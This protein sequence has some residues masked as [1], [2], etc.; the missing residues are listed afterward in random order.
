MQKREELMFLF[1]MPDSYEYFVC[2]FHVYDLPAISS[3]GMLV[4]SH[5]I[6]F[7]SYFQ[8]GVWNLRD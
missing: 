3:G 1:T 5:I 8:Q 6:Y 2:C 7:V 4:K